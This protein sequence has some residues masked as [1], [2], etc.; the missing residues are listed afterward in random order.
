MDGFLA[1]LAPVLG[2]DNGLFEFGANLVRGA[3]VVTVLLFVVYA[4]GTRFGRVQTSGAA[5][6]RILAIRHFRWVGLIAA[7]IGLLLMALASAIGN[8]A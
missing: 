4:L 2:T 5:G 6:G 1:R 8:A 7:L 3:G